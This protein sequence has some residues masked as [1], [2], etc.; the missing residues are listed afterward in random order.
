MN[1]WVVAQDC[2]VLQQSTTIAQNGEFESDEAS[3][4]QNFRHIS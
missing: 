4:T 1:L 2:A 3:Y